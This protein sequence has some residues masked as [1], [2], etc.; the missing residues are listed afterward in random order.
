MATN[1]SRTGYPFRKLMGDLHLWLGVASGL[2]LFAV[3]LSGT[4]LVFRQEITEALNNRLYQ[5]DEAS[6]QGRKPLPL[7]QLLRNVA[8]HAKGTVTGIEIP[9]DKYRAWAFTISEP[10]QN[11]GGRGPQAAGPPSYQ[12][13][14][15]SQPDTAAPRHL[16]H[17]RRQALAEA[18]ASQPTNQAA[19]PQRY[20]T[21]ST[22][23]VANPAGNGRQQGSGHRASAHHRPAEASAPAELATASQPADTAHTG[24]FNSEHQ[25]GTHTDFHR[26]GRHATDSTQVAGA[27]G[28]GHHGGRHRRTSEG[29]PG[30]ALAA[31][32]APADT[33]QPASHKAWAHAGAGR[34]HGGQHNWQLA[35]SLRTKKATDS[36]G[37]VR[38]GSHQEGGQ[39]QYAG[40][41]QASAA[42]ALAMADGRRGNDPRMQTT[43][44]EPGP[45]RSGGRG[46]GMGGRGGR[47]ERGR[48]GGGGHGRS[49]SYLVNPY[50]GE[51][52]GKTTDL[53]GSGFFSFMLNLHR[54][55][56]VERGIGSLVV[57][58]ATLIFLVLEVTGLVLWAP[59]KLKQWRNWKMWKPGFS[60]KW[61][62]NWKRINHDL[63]NTLGFYSFG[64]LT[65]MA[66]TGLCWSFGWFREGT[67]AL[68]GAKVFGGRNEQRLPSARPAAPG[69]TLSA[70]DFLALANQRLPY[71]GT[72]RLSLPEGPTASAGV[73]K[74]RMGFF[75]PAAA[76]RLTL[77]QYT[78]TLLKADIFA[79]KPWNE[80]LVASIRPLHF[81]DV[82]GTF[83]KILYFLACLIATSL[84][85]TGVIIW[86]NR[87]RKK[88]KRKPAA[89][90]VG[91]P[92]SR[93]TEGTQ[94]VLAAVGTSFGQ[95]DRRELQ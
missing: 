54:R 30:L 49:P 34:P 65:V 26:R 31:T 42:P 35:S 76:D 29:E 74:T 71:P 41:A 17:G 92:A 50:T 84:P 44:D 11:R 36:A 55:A 53:A 79:E 67:S 60:I 95:P 4:A 3:C 10:R 27:P 91:Q 39:R 89:R 69:R 82:Y 47:G 78:G 15:G 19:N 23:P 68:F 20:Q 52:L 57:G 66:L 45:S 16:G 21:A 40:P 51:I 90:A 24:R 2:I 13:G 48:A 18:A 38:H 75:A 93:T 14:P 87:L 62:A 86:L 85:I 5:L 88:N 58:I 81:G 70:D 6:V 32:A 9:A 80:Q 28:A 1:P 12:R 63:H 94:P 73:Q 8:A 56:L 37:L 72:V 43:A 61:D 25:R 33:A 64:L 59:A 83:T 77:D 46:E 22:Q 7:A